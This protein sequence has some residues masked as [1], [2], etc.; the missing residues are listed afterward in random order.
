M[1]DASYC[2]RLLEVR[3]TL[4]DG[5]FAGGGNTK[6][7]T[8]VPIRARIEKTGPPD[9]NKATLEMR[10]L[11]YEDIDQLST[12]AFRPLAFAR[13]LVQIYAGNEND[14]LALAFSGEITQAAADFNAA[15]DVTLKIDAMTGYY[16]NITPQGPTAIKGNQPAADFIAQ[17]AAALGYTFQNNGVTAQLSN[18]VF[19]GSPVAQAR[20]AARQIGAELLIDDGVMSLSPVGGGTGTG[21]R[22]GSGGGSVGGSLAVLLNKE[23]GMIG[24]P[25]LTNEG[26]EI[27]SLY[28][29]SYRLGGLVKVESIVPKASGVWRIIKLTH[30]LAAF[31]PG[32]GPWESNLTGF[33]PSMSGPGGKI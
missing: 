7:V 13:N 32:G 28:N 29:P 3:I 19:N 1:A 31:D 22:S 16:G 15:P 12:V 18:A 20:A 4:R 9:F 30:E 33:Y 5:E 14:G 17:Q 2:K 26:V 21:T 27:R 23:S 24:Y 25:T 6:I 8:E 11:L 10:G